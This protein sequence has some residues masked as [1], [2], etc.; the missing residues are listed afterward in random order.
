MARKRN[1]WPERAARLSA[2]ES[3]VRPTPPEDDPT[4]WELRARLNTDGQ[5]VLD[6]WLTALSAPAGSADRACVCCRVHAIRRIRSWLRAAEP[7]TAFDLAQ[8]ERECLCP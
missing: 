5:E 2:L 8:I 1:P 4:L 6:G 3:T 7:V